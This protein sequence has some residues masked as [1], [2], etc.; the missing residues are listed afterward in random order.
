MVKPHVPVISSK[1]KRRSSPTTAPSRSTANASR[2]KARRPAK[3]RST[4]MQSSI[5]I[6]A[7]TAAENS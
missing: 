5:W 3:T 2:A 1:K 6:A 4:R 7:P